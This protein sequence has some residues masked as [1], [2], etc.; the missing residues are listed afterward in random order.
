MLKVNDIVLYIFTSNLEAEL[1]ITKTCRWDKKEGQVIVK[2]QSSYPVNEKVSLLE[3]RVLNLNTNISHNMILM[4]FLLVVVVLL[5]LV[6]FLLV[7]V[8][9]LLEL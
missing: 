6:L 5:Q 9:I 3:M 7:V 2:Q 1:L 8:G 4:L